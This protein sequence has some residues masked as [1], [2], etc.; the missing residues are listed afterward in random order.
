MTV[1]MAAPAALVHIHHV[2]G[3]T[4]GDASP[5]RLDQVAGAT[6]ARRYQ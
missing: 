3:C 1:L 4:T 5:A 2:F 6:A